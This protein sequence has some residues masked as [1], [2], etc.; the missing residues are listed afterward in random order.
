MSREPLSAARNAIFV[1]IYHGITCSI[2]S[3]DAWRDG[4]AQSEGRPFGGALL[5]LRHNKDQ[6]A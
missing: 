4:A 2:E 5:L 1:V 6:T 3:P